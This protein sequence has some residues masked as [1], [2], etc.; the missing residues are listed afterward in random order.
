MSAELPHP[1]GQ[2]ADDIHEAIRVAQGARTKPKL[3]L[4][5][6]VIIAVTVVTLGWLAGWFAP[7][8]PIITPQTCAGHVEVKGAGSATVSPAMLAWASVYNTSTCAKVTYLTASSGISDLAAKSVDFA[9]IDGQLTPAQASELGGSSLTLPVTLEATVVAYN[10]PGVPSGIHLTG[11]LLAAIY[12]GNITNWNN[13]DIQALNPT[14]HFPPTLAITP[15]HCSSGCATTPV[16]TGY[17][18]RSNVT[19]NDTIGNNSNPAW[20]TGT[21]AVGSPGVAI[22]VNT[23]AGAIGY[24][25]LPVAQQERLSWADL[26]NPN[27]TFVAPSAMN[28]TAAAASANPATISESGSPSNQSLVDEAGAS[29]Y[30]MATESYVV[31]YTDVGVAYNGAVTANT[32]QW[33]GT[34]ILWVSTAAQDRG[35]PLGFAPLPGSILVWNSDTIEKLLYYGLPVL[36]G[37]D[38]DGGL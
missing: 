29:T 10:V 30:P 37:G 20:P 35:S 23:T 17:L 19:W 31:L 22:A 1:P 38:A 9:V 34:Y 28:T 3:A 12:L 24:L 25:E 33:I 36:S 14:T 11:A 4:T 27:G 13:S 16:F 18:A 32:A 26:Q 21:G 15:V 7:T 8:A 6:V 5:I 2:P